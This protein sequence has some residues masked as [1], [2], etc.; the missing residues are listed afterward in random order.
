MTESCWNKLLGKEI[1]TKKSNTFVGL[2]L[3]VKVGGARLGD[4]SRIALQSKCARE[5]I[6]VEWCNKK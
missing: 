1:T 6:P 5:R 3:R 4:L 2:T